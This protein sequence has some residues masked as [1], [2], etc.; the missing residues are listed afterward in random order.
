MHAS[1]GS[2]AANAHEQAARDYAGGPPQQGAEERM[3]EA[4][5]RVRCQDL[6]LR[7]LAWREKCMP[8]MWHAPRSPFQCPPK[9]STL[10]GSSSADD[11]T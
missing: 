4:R 10:A 6:H 3:R 11:F 2:R 9:M 7:R 5:L 8:P 1:S